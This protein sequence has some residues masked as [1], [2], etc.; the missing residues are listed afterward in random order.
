MRSIRSEVAVALKKSKVFWIST[1][2]FSVIAWSTG[3]T[4]S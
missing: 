1:S 3:R 4:V 2:T